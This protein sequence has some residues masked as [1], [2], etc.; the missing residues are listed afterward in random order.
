MA[1]A[2][3]PARGGDSTR[4][5]K[6]LAFEQGEG[7]VCWLAHNGCEHLKGEA[8]LRW[9]SHG[10]TGGRSRR[11][12]CTGKNVGMTLRREDE[13]RERGPKRGLTSSVE[14]VDVDKTMS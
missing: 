2:A 9:R 1:M 4:V 13:Q 5:R 6:E 8:E 12:G 11:S 14:E 3:T 10:G 7:G